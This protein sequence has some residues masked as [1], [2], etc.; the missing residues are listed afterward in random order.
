MDSLQF[1]NQLAE[2]IDS[3]FRHHQELNDHREIHPWLTGSL[4][5]PFSGIWFVGENPSLR[6][7]ERAS[8]SS[9]IPLTKEAQWAE[10]RGDCLFREALVRYGF[11]DG[12]V[13]SPGGWHCYITNVMK[14][15]DYTHRVREK[16]P[17]SRQ[18]MANL[19]L[20]VLK[21]ELEHSDPHIV[22]AMG[23][24][25]FDLLTYLHSFAALKLP[26]I[27][28]MTHYAYVGQRARGHQGPMHPERVQEYYA[29]MANIARKHNELSKTSK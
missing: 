5:D 8:N 6:M 20:P 12:C 28:K 2:H 4:G 27:L 7:V 24:Q 23:G 1:E 11:K 9:G 19:W 15:A 26:C 16:S 22:V 17:E 18:E 14:E 21:W 13:D 25:V 29:E 3:V 10:S